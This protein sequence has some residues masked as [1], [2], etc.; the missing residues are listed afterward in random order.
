MSEEYFDD[1][2]NFGLKNQERNVFDRVHKGEVS[3]FGGFDTGGNKFTTPE[4][5]AIENIIKI[6]NEF[7]QSNSNLFGEGNI[8]PFLKKIEDLPKL[9]IR[10]PLV[11][12]LAYISINWKEKKI[13]NEKIEKVFKVISK[14]TDKDNFTSREDVVRYCRFLLK[15]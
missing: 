15:K 3:K 9:D 5:K 4:A 10:N 13:D 12:I 7:S 1:D 2:D 6:A 14:K 11:L 8:Q